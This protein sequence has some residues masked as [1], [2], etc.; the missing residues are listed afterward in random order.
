MYRTQTYDASII[1]IGRTVSSN[2]GYVV[3]EWM[4]LDRL[5]VECCWLPCVRFWRFRSGRRLLALPLVEICCCFLCQEFG[6]GHSGEIPKCNSQTCCCVVE[7]LEWWVCVHLEFCQGM[8]CAQ[9][10]KH[11]KNR[12]V[13]R[14]RY[15][16][17]TLARA[18]HNSR[19][20]TLYGSF[21]PIPGNWLDTRIARLSWS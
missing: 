7:E 18:N 19:R 12:C 20:A 15:V 14:F 5:H 10:K 11:R 4:Q 21:V 13:V 16:R 1:R 9:D 2:V 6:A 8:P 17:A 3:T